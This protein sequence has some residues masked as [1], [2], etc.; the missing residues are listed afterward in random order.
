LFRKLGDSQIT[1]VESPTS[2]SPSECVSENEIF[3]H[4][5]TETQVKKQFSGGTPNPHALPTKFYQEFHK[6]TVPLFCVNF[7]NNRSTNETEGS[8]E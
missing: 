6:C 2:V 5:L 3:V 7:W 1:I 4:H 8:Q